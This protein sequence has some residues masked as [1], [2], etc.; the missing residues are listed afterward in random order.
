MIVKTV[1]ITPEMAREML[2]KNTNNRK[3][4]L[5]EVDKWANEM[6]MGRWKLN[7]T[8]IIINDNL[9]IDGQH[10]LMACVKAG[11]GFWT[12]VVCD[13]SSDVF[14]TIDVGRKRRASD[15]L[16]QKREKSAVLLASTIVFVDQYL[17]GKLRGARQHTNADIEQILE[18]HPGLRRSVD[19]VSAHKLNR[20][21]QPSVLAGCHYLFA[22]KNA[23]DADAFVDK[24]VLGTNLEPK[25]GPYLLR[26]RLLLNAMSKS[27]LPKIEIAALVIKAWN[28]EQNKTRLT[29]LRWRNKGDNPERFPTIR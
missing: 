4:N 24:I 13:A 16:Y 18:N 23:D 7:G 27:K 8:T 28:A 26:E 5:R 15:T 29:Y 9:L 10:R 12:L 11:V 3:P 1:F 21:I 19:K 25:T 22:Q 14:D 2:E 17:T 6:K 20:L